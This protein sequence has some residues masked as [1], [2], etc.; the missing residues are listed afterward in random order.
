MN[1]LA[2]MLLL[3]VPFHPDNAITVN[4]ERLAVVVVV[5]GMSYMPAFQGCLMEV[6]LTPMVEMAPKRFIA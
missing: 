5:L 2:R 3:E 6:R 4:G 1:L